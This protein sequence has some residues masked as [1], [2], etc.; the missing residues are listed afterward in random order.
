M[1]LASNHLVEPPGHPNPPPAA[2]ADLW[3]LSLPF[4]FSFNRRCSYNRINGLWACE[5]PLTLTTI[6]KGYYNFSGFVVS[7]WGACH[8]TSDFINGG[9]DIEM[10]SGKNFNEAKIQAALDAKEV[11][12]LALTLTILQPL[13]V[14]LSHCHRRHGGARSRSCAHDRAAPRR[15]LVPLSPTQRR[16][17][18]SRSRSRSLSRSPS[19]VFPLDASPVLSLD[20]SPAAVLSRR[21]ASAQITMGQLRDSCVRVLRGWY[22]LPVDKRY[23]CGGAN[24]IQNNVSTP[25]HKDLARKIAAQSTVL[26]KNT[27]VRKSYCS[28]LHRPAV[29]SGTDL[30]P[31]GCTGRRRRVPVDALQPTRFLSSSSS[32]SS[33]FQNLLPLDKTKK[34]KIALIGDDAARP[35]VSGQ[36]SGGVGTS[37]R[38]VSP[39]AAF[40]AR[41]A[42]VNFTDHSDV[43]AMVAAAKAADIAIVFGSAHSGEGHDRKDLNLEDGMD[44]AIAAVAAAQ[45]NTVVAVTVPGQI[46]TD[47]RD[48]VP[49]ILVAFLP[50]EQYVPPR[51]PNPICDAL[52][53]LSG[54]STVVGRLGPTGVAEQRVVLCIC[55][56]LDS[57]SVPPS[58]ADKTYIAVAGIRDPH[59]I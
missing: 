9:L 8:G 58:S 54:E 50:G 4:S 18:L 17:P 14:I 16:S 12:A 2:A 38:L 49:A 53:G 21:F 33:F 41:G 30:P 52:P 43:D 15:P 34:L 26:V 29:A 25:E 44:A 46:L 19:P 22:S 36:G 59:H 56:N 42:D 55:A 47:W 39:L 13:P 40:Q 35:Y 24:C 27:G 32:S 51:R 5:D 6:L 57:H 11:P 23:P 28:S 37:D 45:K 10:P 20:V 1:H 31:P 3:P 48:S 7:D